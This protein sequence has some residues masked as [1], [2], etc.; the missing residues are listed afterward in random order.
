[1]VEKTLIFL[2]FLNCYNICPIPVYFRN[3]GL[4]TNNLLYLTILFSSCM[5]NTD[6]IRVYLQEIGRI[7][8]LTADEEITLARQIQDLLKIEHDRSLLQ[9]DLGR[10]PT[11]F[12]SASLMGIS[13][14]ELKCRLARGRAAKNKMI[15]ANLRLVVSIVKKYQNRGLSLQDLIQE[16]TIGLVKAAEKFDPEKGYKFSTYA[17]WWVRQ[18]CMRSI[19]AQS[20]TIRLPIH[21]TE[22]LNKIR[23]TVKSLSQSLLRQPTYK[24]IAQAVDIPIERL[25]FL[26][27]KARSIDS[28]DR[29]IG[30]EEDTTIGE[31]I[32]DSASSIET[33]IIESC[34]SDEVEASLANLT[35][36]EAKVL[37]LRYGLDDGIA[38][39]LSEVAEPL[40]CSR[41]RVRQ[42]EARALRKLRHNAGCQNLK[43]YL[44]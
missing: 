17:T 28:L 38:K 19:A 3:R 24:E 26:M 4:S 32:A 25:K 39:T 9:K 35:T 6:S 29:G 5:S 12:E 11:L 10:L 31:L 34:L 7:Q 37:R 41:E 30:K 23:K 20:R 33:Q 2:F 36:R 14:K 15:A 42:I 13:E 16:G 22:K 1:M 44:D 43:E 18:A 21:V 40:K 27:G 8:M